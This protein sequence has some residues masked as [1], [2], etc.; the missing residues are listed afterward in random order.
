MVNRDFFRELVRIAVCLLLG[1]GLGLVVGAPGLGAM[2]SALL[3]ALWCA[4]QLALL[5]QWLADDEQLDPPESGGIWASVFDVLYRQRKAQRSEHQRLA[6]EANYFAEGAAALTDGVIMLD[7]KG[8]IMWC[9]EATEGLLGVTT[10]EDHGQLLVNLLRDPDFMRY[11]QAADF[12][13]GLELSSPVNDA[14]MLHLETTVFGEGNRLMLIRDVTQISQVERMRVDFIANVSHELRTPLTV[15][16]GYL[17]SLASIVETVPTATLERALAQMQSQSNRMQALV[18]DITLLSRL[19]SEPASIQRTTVDVNALVAM[20]VDDARCSVGKD[21]QF[22]L[23]LDSGHRLYGEEK[24]LHSAFGNL[25]VNACKYTEAGGSITIRWF[26][27]DEQAYFEVEDNGVGIDKSDIPHL[28]K[29]FYRVDKSRS[30]ESGGTGL[31][32]AIVKHALLRHDAQLE[33]GSERGRGSVFRC[34]FPNYRI[35]ERAA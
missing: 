16:N 23:E 21:K 30:T 31:G 27:D 8:M 32:L 15:I 33:I 20:L 11:F 7:Q 14:M 5:K 10:P 3:Y 19:E 4:R 13:S 34:V 26:V 29:R 6:R 9:N 17:E 12:S 28:T 2:V 24:A 22:K 1:A 35:A 25:V 18:T